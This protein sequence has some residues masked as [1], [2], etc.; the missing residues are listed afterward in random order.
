M[1]NDGLFFKFPFCSAWGL[2]SV[3]MHSTRINGF[4]K[5]TRLSTWQQM[6]QLKAFVVLM[7]ELAATWSSYHFISNDAATSLWINCPLYFAAPTMGVDSFMVVRRK[8]PVT[9]L[10]WQ[11][12]RKTQWDGEREDGN[13]FGFY[14]RA[15][16]MSKCPPWT[17]VNEKKR[18]FHFVEGSKVNLKDK[19]F[20]W[21]LYFCIDWLYILSIAT[22]IV[23]R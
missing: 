7:L 16:W 8:P 12:E 19:L 2:A 18:S 13:E 22:V 14:L 1:I 9:Q 23:N 15:V 11:P 5:P 20:P 3:D 17:V 4:G 10:Q 6:V 21:N